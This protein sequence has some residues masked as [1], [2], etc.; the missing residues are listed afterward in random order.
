MKFSWYV[1]ALGNVIYFVPVESN[2]GGYREL[3]MG[4]EIVPGKGSQ[5]YY[6]FILRNN[7]AF[8][9]QLNAS[10]CNICLGIVNSSRSDKMPEDDACLA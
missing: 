7:I 10:E 4:L 8:A 5:G 9:E 6:K 2:Q 1:E 3:S